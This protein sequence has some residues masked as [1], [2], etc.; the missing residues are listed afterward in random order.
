MFTAE[1]DKTCFRD[2]KKYGSS[3]E[4]AMPFVDAMGQEAFKLN[5]TRS[6][7]AEVCWCCPP[8]HVLHVNCCKYD[9]DQAEYRDFK[10]WSGVQGG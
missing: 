8:W 1:E 10:H 7:K 3:R 9:N 6:L 5:K 2:A 4:F